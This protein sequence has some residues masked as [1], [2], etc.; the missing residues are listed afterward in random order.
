MLSSFSN[1]SAFIYLTST[2]VKGI[3][4]N[5]IAL[6][7]LIERFK[8]FPFRYRNTFGIVKASLI[9]LS[10]NAMFLIS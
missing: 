4:N 8:Q 5:A 1:L 9:L 6:V 3:I 10:L 2:L 7:A